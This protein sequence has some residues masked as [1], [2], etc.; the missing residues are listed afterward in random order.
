MTRFAI[1]RS[2]FT[3]PY[4]VGPVATPWPPPH[5]W[6]T[7]TIG[8]GD[9]TFPP[10]IHLDRGEHLV[11]LEVVGYCT[12]PTWEPRHAPTLATPLEGAVA[13]LAVGAGCSGVTAIVG[14]AAFSEIHEGTAAD[15][16]ASW[17]SSSRFRFVIPAFSRR[18]AWRHRRLSAA[19]AFGLAVRVAHASRKSLANGSSSSGGAGRMAF[20]GK[21]WRTGSGSTDPATSA[22]M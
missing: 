13:L 17:I 14:Q 19:L 11:T 16:I 20:A 12:V 18:I 15:E 9:L 2:G 6:G 7:A 4:S 10:N 5:N 1:G 21:Q 22:A 8:I 3:A